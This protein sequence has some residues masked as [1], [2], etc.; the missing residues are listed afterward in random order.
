MI[1]ADTE[2][3]VDVGTVLPEQTAHDFDMAVPRCDVQGSTA[4]LLKFVDA[5]GEG[6]EEEVKER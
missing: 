5:V 6:V 2:L 3:E 1:L 4:V